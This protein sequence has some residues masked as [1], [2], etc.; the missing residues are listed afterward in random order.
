[1]YP[2]RQIYRVLLQATG[3]NAALD[4]P[5]VMEDACQYL[6]VAIY[7]P[8]HTALGTGTVQLFLG[9]DSL[10][11]ATN[12]AG[13]HLLLPVFP[14]AGEP[15]MVLPGSSRTFSQVHA[16]LT[17]GASSGVFTTD[18]TTIGKAASFQPLQLIARVTNGNAAAIE[19]MVDW[20]GMVFRSP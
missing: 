12:F 3:G 9:G 1:M 4:V 17:A 11:T 6:N 8:G 5:F 10:A 16:T 15:H 18:K 14:Q 13:N 7:T 19:L 20:S 2:F